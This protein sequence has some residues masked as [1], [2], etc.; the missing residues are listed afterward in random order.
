MHTDGLQPAR[1]RDLRQRQPRHDDPPAAG[2]YAKAIT[3]SGDL[4]GDFDI[5]TSTTIAGAGEASTEIKGG[6]SERIFDISSPTAVIDASIT[7]LRLSGGVAT[8]SPGGADRIAQNGRVRLSHSSLW[9]NTAQGQG[10]SGGAISV[11]SKTASIDIDDVTF[12]LNRA[13]GT[14]NSFVHAFGGAIVAS[15][16]SVSISHST[17]LHNVVFGRDADSSTSAGGAYGRGDCGTR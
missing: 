11:A 14:D 10:P 15:F 7:G 4:A 2:S 9:N 12:A 17:F 5:H 6:G 3:G 16:G 8:E 13:E 1:G